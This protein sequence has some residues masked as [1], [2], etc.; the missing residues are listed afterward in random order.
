MYFEYSL[1]FHCLP[2]NGI[3]ETFEI[4]MFLTFIQVSLFFTWGF[5]PSVPCLI[6]CSLFLDYHI[7]GRKIAEVGEEN[8]PKSGN[9][10]ICPGCPQ[11]KERVALR[12]CWKAMVE[13]EIKL[14][15]LHTL[16]SLSFSIRQTHMLPDKLPLLL[17]T[18]TAGSEWE[19]GWKRFRG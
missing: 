8:N 19:E 15:P 5:L 18:P 7:G 10:G 2:F 1:H 11:W 14:F 17:P 12:M 9:Y 3:C 16:Q 4:L 6:R 13:R